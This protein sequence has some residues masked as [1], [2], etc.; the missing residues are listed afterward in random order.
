MKQIPNIIT[1]A[2]LFCGCIA[3]VYAVEANF[4]YASSFVLLGIFFDFFDGLAARVLNVAGP[5]GKQLDSLA[6][7]VTSGV[8]PGI[9]MFQLIHINLNRNT[10]SLVY[11]EETHL[12]VGLIGL[13]LALAAAYRLAKFNIDERQTKS[14]IGLPTPA[15]SMFVISLP[16][17]Q[18]Y[19]DIEFAKYLIANNYFLISLTWVL[20]YLMNAEIPLFSLKF[21]EFSFSENYIKYLFL[22]MSI[23]LIWFIPFLSIPVII[24]LYVVLSLIKKPKFFKEE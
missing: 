9:I 5:F 19:S 10:N 13:L 22:L 16:L 18:Q 4:L 11:N 21:E 12:D 23:A 1:L 6:D 3:A 2:N 14:F 20:C 24:I 15:M 8:V 7:V 17:I